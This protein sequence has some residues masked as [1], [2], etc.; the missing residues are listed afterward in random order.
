MYLLVRVVGMIVDAVIRVGDLIFWV[1]PP[2]S[3]S[4]SA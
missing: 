1:R 3:V 2:F 4:T